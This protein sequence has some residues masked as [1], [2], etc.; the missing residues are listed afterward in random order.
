MTPLTPA[1]PLS[2]APGTTAMTASLPTWGCAKC[3]PQHTPAQPHR[4][5]PRPRRPSPARPVSCHWQTVAPSAM[6]ARLPAPNPTRTPA[7]YPPNPTP[8]S[9]QALCRPTTP[10]STARE[11]TRPSPMQTQPASSLTTPRQVPL[12]ACP[13]QLCQASPLSCM[14]SSS[15]VHATRCLLAHPACAG[16][17]CKSQGSLPGQGRL[18]GDIQHRRVLRPASCS[19]AGSARAQQKAPAAV[20]P[21]ALRQ[22]TPPTAAEEQYAV[23]S[24]LNPPSAYWI[25]AATRAPPANQ[26]L[27]ACRP[28]EGSRPAWRLR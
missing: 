1:L 11:T 19:A 12:A 20:L 10:T 2:L 27:R 4:R 17:L 24:T 6:S 7:A 26:T 21:P 14:P 5:R 18:A 23:E 9:L 13:C 28:A 8:P 16:H 25:G 3:P 22:N 15:A